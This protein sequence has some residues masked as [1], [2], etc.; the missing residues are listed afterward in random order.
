MPMYELVLWHQGNEDV[1]I[2]DQPVSVGQTVVIDKVRWLVEAQDLPPRSERSSAVYLFA[3]RREFFQS[4]HQTPLARLEL[5][6]PRVPTS[7][8]HRRECHYR[9]RWR[10]ALLL[11]IV[12]ATLLAIAQQPDKASL[13]A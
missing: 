7:A 11:S 13:V 10:H 5:R 9:T 6:W 8:E 3:P 12:S 1:R 2:T 4:K